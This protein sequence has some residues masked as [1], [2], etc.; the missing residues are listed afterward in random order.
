MYIL[1]HRSDIKI[2]AKSRHNF[3]NIDYY[4]VVKDNSSHSNFRDFD[5]TTVTAILLLNIDEK[6]SEFRRCVRKCQT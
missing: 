5:T 6:F 2:A 1:L 3:G 4:I